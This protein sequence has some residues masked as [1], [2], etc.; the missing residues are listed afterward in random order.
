MN[1][2]PTTLIG[3]RQ[4]NR[5]AHTNCGAGD[6][7]DLPFQLFRHNLLPVAR[8]CRYPRVKVVFGREHVILS[9]MKRYRLALC[10]A[11]APF[12][13]CAAP[14]RALDAT[15]TE[16]QNTVYVIPVK[17]MIEPALVYVM[18][19]GVQEA[20][21]Q[22]AAAVI[23]EMDT[24]G[25]RLDAATDI[26]RLM[27]SVRV[28]TYTFVEKNA[29]SAGAIIALSTKKI[30]MAPGSVIGDAM[31]IM[32]TPTGGAQEMPEAIEEKTV[33]A[34]S[35][36]I[37]AAAQESGHDPQL[38]EAMVRREIEYKIGDEVISKEGQLLTLTNVEA[39]REVGEAGERR[40][41]ISEGTL[42]DIPALLDTVGLTNSKII[43]LEVTSV[44]RLAR[45]IAAASSLLLMAGLLGI[46]IEFKTPGFGLPGILGIAAIALFFWGHHIA[47]LAGME[48][49]ALFL[50][51]LIFIG[52]EVF[53]LPGHAI[54][55]VVGITLVLY[56]LLSAMVER[57]PGS[58]WKLEM[59]MIQ[60]PLLKLAAGIVL[61]AIA[62]AFVVRSLPRSR[63]GHWLVL[64]RATTVNEGYTGATA[65]TSFLGQRGTT[66]TQLRPSGGALFG[67][68]RVDVIT[69]GEFIDANTPIR[70]TSVSGNRIVVEA[71]TPSTE[72]T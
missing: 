48:N 14:A 39:E 31:P 40:H 37:R 68:K 45:M 28:P 52:I 5:P 13:F 49:V 20:E 50:L 6:D 71:D 4:C 56:S 51:G 55:G 11:L 62:G 3:Q 41:L 23:L 70:V 16:K 2:N 57:V 21:R 58:A 42:A 10:L 69:S 66:A 36:L 12:F 63:A 38:A 18:R 26:V 34:V 61:A 7:C 24:L 60:M 29:I 53:V 32:M 65:E 64:D 67:D 1:D 59:D 19:R 25:G 47:G 43:T 27:Q 72:N 33:S 46:Y 17:G 8:R 15:P 30:Y 44:E 9:T 35:A 22:N 54:P